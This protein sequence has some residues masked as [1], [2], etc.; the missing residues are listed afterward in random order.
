MEKLGIIEAQVE[1]AKQSKGGKTRYIVVDVDGDCT[2][3]V[4]PPVN[5][6]NLAAVY[7]NGSEDKTAKETT[8]EPET[9]AP[10]TKKGKAKNKKV[11]KTKGK[12]VAKPAAKKD[13]KPRKNYGTM[14]GP[15]V[16]GAKKTLSVDQMVKE[17]KA[18]KTIRN[19][20]GFYYSPKFL[21]SRKDRT[22]KHDVFV[23][24]ALK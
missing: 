7:R 24:E 14:Y 1:A 3:E 9:A 8:P 17:L 13:R 23:R 4:K 10:V 22:K 15:K 21:A 16:T 20:K 11:M 5:L 2:V 18:G 19:N 6:S 12:K